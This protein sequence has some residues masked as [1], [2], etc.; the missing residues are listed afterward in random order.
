ML[1]FLKDTKNI[2]RKFLNVRNI[3]NIQQDTKSKKDSVA[4]LNIHKEI[5][6]SWEIRKTNLLTIV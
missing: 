2:I 4:F 6:I 3:F 5:V 1:L